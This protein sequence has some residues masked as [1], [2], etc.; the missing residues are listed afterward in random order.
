MGLAFSHKPEI[1]IPVYINRD[2]KNLIQ[3]HSDKQNRK[4]TLYFGVNGSPMTV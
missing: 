4:W 1:K 2:N 3:L